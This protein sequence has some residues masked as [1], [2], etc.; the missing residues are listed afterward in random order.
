[1]VDIQRVW[2]NVSRV[3]TSYVD[4]TDVIGGQSCPMRQIIGPGVGV[5]LPKTV[6]SIEKVGPDMKEGRAE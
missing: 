5:R 2:L 1:M 6:V 3:N 4:Y